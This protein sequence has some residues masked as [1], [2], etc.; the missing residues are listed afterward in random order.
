MLDDNESD[1]EVIRKKSYRINTVSL[2]VRL[3]HYVILGA[4]CSEPLPTLRL[5]ESTVRGLLSFRL[6]VVSNKYR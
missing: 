3:R 4:S 2:W 6:L 5:K 1:Q